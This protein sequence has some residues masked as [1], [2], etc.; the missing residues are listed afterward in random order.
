MADTIRKV[1]YYY[2]MVS[3]RS[4]EAAQI[5]GALRDAGVNLMG[6]SGFP[7]GVRRA[8]LD[9]I[10][11]SPAAFV[12]AA[13]KA[14]LKLSGKKTGFL[15]QG[16]DRPGAVAEIAGKLSGAGINITAVEALCAGAGRYGALLWVKQPDVRRAAKA[17]GAS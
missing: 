13:R 10:P 2:T 12:R 14:R 1:D 16:E 15:I 5:L 7:R 11:E 3:D 4:G 8:Q 6:F 9:F 17:L